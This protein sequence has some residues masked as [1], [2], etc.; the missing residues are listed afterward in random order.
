MPSS[1]VALSDDVDEFRHTLR[2][3]TR[4]YLITGQGRF[5]GA[6]TRIDLHRLWMQRMDE[7][8]PR[9]WCTPV[10]RSAI[11]FHASPGPTMISQG[12]GITADDVGVVAP[13]VLR[14]HTLSGASHFASMSLTADDLSALGP[15][16]TGHDLRISPDSISISATPTVMDRLRRLHAAAVHLAETAPEIIANRDAARGLES[17][18]VE[19]FVD[20]L[21]MG[22][23]RV[24]TSAERR[25]G[26]ILF[27]LR[28][29]AEEHPDEPLYLTD[30]CAAIGVTQRTL[31]MCCQEQFGISPKRFLMLR[32]LHLARRTLR[33]ASPTDT[34]V[35]EVAT[36][37]G[38]WELGRF[39]TT[40]RAIFGETPSRTLRERNPKVRA[41][42]I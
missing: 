9:V 23:A 2:P 4:E 13:G 25:H 18:L 21:S 33:A 14:W 15:T 20:C 27:R 22:R 42:T 32:R 6:V 7:T 39:A 37:F 38:F 41:I 36:R 3:G 35:T 24:D 26:A 30:V 40:Y 31:M 10:S 19:A 16:L 12:I 1:M 11:Y 28:Q 34:S 29:L 8:L 17:S 5:S